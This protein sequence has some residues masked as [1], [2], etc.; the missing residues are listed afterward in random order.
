MHLLIC[1]FTN[2]ISSMVQHKSPHEYNLRNT[3]P[4]LDHQILPGPIPNPSFPV[5][6]GP[7]KRYL[8]GV[9]QV[10][11]PTDVQQPL[12]LDPVGQGL[13]AEL[14]TPG[15]QRL[16]DPVRKHTDQSGMGWRGDGEWNLQPL[17]L[18]LNNRSTRLSGCYPWYCCV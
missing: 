15:G 12:L 13:E 11:L 9:L 5:Y 2:N 4:V 16:D 18:E 14:R 17:Y 6:V 10:L 7:I 8:F 3:C 1:T